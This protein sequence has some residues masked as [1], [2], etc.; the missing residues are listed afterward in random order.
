[1]INRK[2]IFKNQIDNLICLCYTNLAYSYRQGRTDNYEKKEK[3][4]TEEHYK[5]AKV[6]AM[7]GVICTAISA[8]KANAIT[9]RYNSFFDIF[10]THFRHIFS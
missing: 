6:F 5:A 1:M 8:L 9:I 7:T 10:L 4:K 3:T 2:G